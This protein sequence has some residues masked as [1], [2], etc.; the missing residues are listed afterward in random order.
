MGTPFYPKLLADI[1]IVL[2]YMYIVSH[3]SA[4]EIYYYWKNIPVYT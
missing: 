4:K 2:Q 3:K 1:N